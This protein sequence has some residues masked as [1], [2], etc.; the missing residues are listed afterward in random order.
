LAAAL[1]GRPDAL[2]LDDPTLGFDSI[3]R[4]ALLGERCATSRITAR[5]HW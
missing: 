1:A 3:A 4:R 5:P 2:I